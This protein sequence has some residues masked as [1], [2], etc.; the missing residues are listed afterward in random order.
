MNKEEIRARRKQITEI[1]IDGLDAG[2]PPAT[3]AHDLRWVM[4]QRQILIL[5]ILEENAPS[6]GTESPDPT[7]TANIEDTTKEIKEASPYIC[8]NCRYSYC[9]RHLSDECRAC[10]HI[11]PSN[12]RPQV[13]QEKEEE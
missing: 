7:P 12:W 2:K 3:K 5:D 9:S 13:R 11:A 6:L 10:R 4:F 1:F 8:A